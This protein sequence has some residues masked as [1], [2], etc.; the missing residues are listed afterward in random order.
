MIS[1]QLTSL[2][3]LSAHCKWKAAW[4]PYMRKKKPA[5]IILHFSYSVSLFIVMCCFKY[6][7]SVC[8]STVLKA[9]WLKFAR[10]YCWLVQFPL[11][12]RTKGS[13]VLF[14]T[15]PLRSGPRHTVCRV[16]NLNIAKGKRDRKT[17]GAACVFGGDFRVN[18]WG[19]FVFFE[20]NREICAT[21]G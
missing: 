13:A 14:H 6:V 9:Y 2:G 19:S 8:L 15:Q 17:D 5:C 4:P 3:C 12:W 21:R 7:S 16:A 10:I 20:G 11:G 18:K 1:F